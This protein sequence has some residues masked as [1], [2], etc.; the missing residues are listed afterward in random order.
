MNKVKWIVLVLILLALL[1]PTGMAFAK[2]HR[3]IVF[4]VR[5][6]A[7]GDIVL[8]L[9]KDKVHNSVTYPGGVTKVV[10][11]EALYDYYINTPC[12]ITAGQLNLDASKTLFVSC[13]QDKL[14]I[15]LDHVR[16]C[17]GVYTNSHEDYCLVIK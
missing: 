9:V 6:R 1:I 3:D 12:G 10:I 13:R 16:A 2:N 5:N 4:T 14:Y 15:M 8:D 11:K 17:R 7:G